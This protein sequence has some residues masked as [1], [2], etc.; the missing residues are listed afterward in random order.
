MKFFWTKFVGMQMKF[1]LRV[2]VLFMRSVEDFAIKVEV[3]EDNDNDRKKAKKMEE[4][5]AKLE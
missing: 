2:T 4:E 1:S 3:E 5:N